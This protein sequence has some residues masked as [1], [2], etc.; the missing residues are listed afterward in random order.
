M[1]AKNTAYGEK[2]QSMAIEENGEK[3][4]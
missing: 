4:A 2:Y 1:P 3:S